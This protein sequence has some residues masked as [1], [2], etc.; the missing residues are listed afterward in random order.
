MFASGHGSGLP[1][2]CG[3]INLQQP[4]RGWTSMTF[5]LSPGIRSWSAARMELRLG[6]LGAGVIAVALAGAASVAQTPST[7]E[8][9]AGY[10]PEK[11]TAVTAVNARPDANRL[12]EMHRT[13]LQA[14]RFAVANLERRRQL[15]QDSARLLQLSAELSLEFQRAGEADLAQAAKADM[16]EKLAHAVQ[17]KMK[18]TVA[19][20]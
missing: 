1:A 20:Q 18:L 2:W 5:G 6:A 15:L 10:H 19:F 4:R 17:E 11:D 3:A 16:I 9:S 13:H 8:P 7:G 14:Q 12:M